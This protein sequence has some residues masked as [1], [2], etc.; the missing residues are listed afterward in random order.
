MNNL[1]ILISMAA[2][3]AIISCASQGTIA[4]LEQADLSEINEEKITCW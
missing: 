3:S 2:M 4:G 1:K